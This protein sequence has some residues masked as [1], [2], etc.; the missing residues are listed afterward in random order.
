[1]RAVIQRVDKANVRI[2][3]EEISSINDGILVL[4]GIEK[5][6]SKSDA[7]YILDKAINLRIFEDEQGK[8]N[9]SLLDISGEVLVVSQFT[10]LGDCARGRRP[11]FSRAEEPAKARELYEYFL[12]EGKLRVKKFVAGHFQEMMKVELVNSGPVTILLDSR[13][14]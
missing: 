6:D 3:N 12:R 5:E 14:R 1:M 4:L 11:S 8:M 7:D 13:L 10:L 9:L 2:N